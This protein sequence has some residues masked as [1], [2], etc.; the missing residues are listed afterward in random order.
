MQA[1][2][3]IIIF[4]VSCHVLLSQEQRQIDSVKKRIPE[5]TSDTSR[6]RN[7]LLLA[8]W[9]ADINEWSAYNQK[10][11]ALAEK[12]LSLSPDGELR[13]VLLKQKAGALNN[14][15]YYCKEINDY[16]K[17]MLNYELSKKIYLDL[18]D[19]EGEATCLTNIGALNVAMGD[20][21]EGVEKYTQALRLFNELDDKGNMATVLN[22]IGNQYLNQGNIKSAF[23]YFNQALKIY[24]ETK[25]ITG[26]VV[27]YRN[28]GSLYFSQKEYQSAFDFYYKA[29]KIY[30]KQNDKLT[31]AKSY[32]DLGVTIKPINRTKSLY[33]DSL[34][35]KLFTELGHEEGI[36]RSY[37][38]LGAALS[39]ENQ[40]ELGLKLVTRSFLI[41]KKLDDLDGM[42][43]SSRNIAEMYLYTHQFDSA[44][45][46][47]NAAYAFAK[48]SGVTR[49][50][51]NAA[52]SLAKI[53]AKLKNFEK[54][55]YYHG[56]FKALNDS[57]VNSNSKNLA[58][59]QLARIEF[60]KREVE[61]K[62][63]QEKK[64]LQ[65][66]DEKRKQKLVITWVSIV[67]VLVIILAVIVLRSL[68]INQKKNRIITEQKH[69][70]DEKQKEII[71]SIRYA[72]RIQ[73]SLM[74]NEK[75]IARKLDE[76][77]K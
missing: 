67:L 25:N 23:D 36:A 31:L 40:L 47:G 62:A 22:N 76:L 3:F 16:K 46:W 61:L 15:G 18:D 42:C 53:H 9:I 34:A 63:E 73:Q 7:Y 56:E 37:N 29:H 2:R 17:A 19:K 77:G 66:E 43:Y 45:H 64:N 13:R 28:L 27:V 50:A 58:A 21:A 4:F 72:K 24:A 68:R 30:E 60:E 35:L 52:E 6:I 71:A 41:R 59:Q 75:Y 8:E 70:V 32:A 1:L 11:L 38:D 51:R 69:L 20:V 65:A 44:L 14:L 54:A 74:P 57:I 5:L 26:E 12:N 48:R 55:Y 33:Y 39:E 10:A 49:H